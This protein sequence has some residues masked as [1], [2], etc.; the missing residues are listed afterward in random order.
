[1]AQ[2]VLSYIQ[3]VHDIVQDE[4]VLFGKG[5]CARKEICYAGGAMY[6]FNKDALLKTYNY[7]A[8]NPN[9]LS[10]HHPHSHQ[11]GVNL[12]EHEDY[13]TSYAYRM[14]TGN[15]VL[16]SEQIY[17]HGIER[18]GYG[19]KDIVPI[20]YH[21]IKAPR[22]YFEYYSLFYDENGKPRGFDEIEQIYLERK[23]LKDNAEKKPKVVHLDALAY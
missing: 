21:N 5:V 14:A 10:E 9:M 11:K 2:N 1:M 7:L 22:L 15:P 23:S 20:C 8:Q 18:D 4:P 12:M 17:N 13:M 19:S 16:S 6:G 3:R